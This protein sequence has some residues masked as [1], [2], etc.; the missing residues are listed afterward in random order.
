MSNVPA[1][2]RKKL[3]AAN[4]Q[5]AEELIVAG[6]SIPRI[7]TLGKVWRLKNGGG[8]EVIQGELEVVILGMLPEGRMSKTYYASGYQDGSKDAPD[9]QSTDGLVPD[10][11]IQSPKST[12]CAKCPMNQFGSLISAAGKQAK[13]CKDSKHLYVKRISDINEDSAPIYMMNIT[14][15]SMKSMTEFAKDIAKEGI[16][17]AAV[18]CKLSFNIESSTP[19]IMF[20][21]S[22]YLADNEVDA[23][24]AK[25]EEAPWKD[26][27]AGRA[28][29]AGSSQSQTAITQ[30][31]PAPVVA[32]P[33]H[34]VV[35]GVV[36]HKT[37]DDDD[38]LSNW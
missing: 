19:Q 7:S 4:V 1:Y 6:A 33:Q 21:M 26:D 18:K 12:S 30:E 13:A 29:P 23:S 15:A 10:G 37:D 8:E 17:P 38:V 27:I 20:T 24:L 3:E 16:P 11:Q 28:L 31:R 9:C 14:W 25:A 36:E 35:D 32:K 34:V 5:G 22:G 2:L